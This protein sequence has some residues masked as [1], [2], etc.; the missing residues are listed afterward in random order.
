[1]LSALPGRPPFFRGYRPLRFGQCN[2]TQFIQFLF[3]LLNIL[4]YHN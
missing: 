4:L 1:M 3:T 2:F